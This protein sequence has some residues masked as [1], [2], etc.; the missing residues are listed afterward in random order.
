MAPFMTPP[1]VIPQLIL[2]LCAVSIATCNKFFN[3]M[4]IFKGAKV[5]PRLTARAGGKAFSWLF[6]TGASAQMYDIFLF[7]CYIS[8]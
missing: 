8:R 6:D 1:S 4:T 2:N 3:Q 5:R 7:P